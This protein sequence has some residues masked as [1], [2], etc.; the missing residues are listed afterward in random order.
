MHGL[1]G[2]HVHLLPVEPKVFRS[3]LDALGFTS[4]LDF[5]HPIVLLSLAFSALSLLQFAFVFVHDI[6][7]KG[8]GLGQ[9]DCFEMPNNGK[10]PSSHGLITNL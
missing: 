3:L 4:N 9:V 1:K 2:C 8:G 5:A 10:Q 7:Q 6:W